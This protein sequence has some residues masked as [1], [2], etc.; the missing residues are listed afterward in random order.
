MGTPHI[1]LQGATT[2]AEAWRRSCEYATVMSGMQAPEP[3]VVALLRTMFYIGFAAGV[4]VSDNILDS[5]LEDD[6]ARALFD[7]I[8]AEL[9]AEAVLFS[10]QH[11]RPLTGAP[12]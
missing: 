11:G 3:D 12:R 1:F 5:D 2:V 9:S 8:W 7:G 10:V 6:K 4:A